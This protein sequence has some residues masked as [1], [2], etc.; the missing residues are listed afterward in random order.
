M[1]NVL[2]KGAIEAV[3][4]RV[5]TTTATATAEELAYLGTALERI[6]GKATVLEVV[7]VADTKLGE[8]TAAMNALSDQQ[9]ARLLARGDEQDARLV[10]QGNTQVDRVTAEGDLQVSVLQSFSPDG[11]QQLTLTPGQ[12]AD[13]TLAAGRHG[14]IGCSDIG[15]AV[16]LPDATTL[17]PGRSRLTL[18]LNKDSFPV[19]VLDATGRVIGQLEPGDLVEFHLLDHG[20]AAGQWDYSGNLAPFWMATSADFQLLYNTYSAYTF[21]SR[22]LYYGRDTSNYPFIQSVSFSGDRIVT[23]PMV[24]LSA[25]AG[26]DIAQVYEIDANRYLVWFGGKKLRVID[27][28]DPTTPV[29]GATVTLVNS[30]HRLDR[31]GT[32]ETWAALRIDTANA[33]IYATPIHLSGAT[34][35][36]GSEAQGTIF[37]TNWHAIYWAFALS[38][39][40][41]GL[42]IQCNNASDNWYRLSA[43]RLL[44]NADGSFTFGTA[45]QYPANA[46]TGSTSNQYQAFHLGGN[47]ALVFYMDSNQRIRTSVCTFD[48]TSSYSADVL[49]NQTTGTW[50][51]TV[52]QL[53]ARRFY[54]SANNKYEIA[55]QVVDVTAVGNAIVQGAVLTLSAGNTLNTN[56]AQL[57]EGRLLLYGSN[58]YFALVALAADGTQTVLQSSFS[59][60]TRNPLFAANGWGGWSVQNLPNYRHVLYLVSQGGSAPYSQTLY[61]VT[62]S[63]DRLKTIPLLHCE[64][65]SV[66]VTSWR[67]DRALMLYGY[68]RRYGIDVG[69]RM[70]FGRDRSLIFYDWVARLGDRQVLARSYL[71]YGSSANDIRLRHFLLKFAEA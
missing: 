12:V 63:N 37:C 59:G 70:R 25:V 2:I 6:G 45:V 16:R 56:V 23:S 62:V 13:I 53:D 69:H 8:M 18:S 17:T 20:T 54:L 31:F 19:G 55:G 58:E 5:Q 24:V 61:R 36:A 64:D 65:G 21:P 48:A 4:D 52:T 26:E 46:N 41:L 71:G 39:S 15:A 68:P 11:V 66:G 3:R 42:L 33:K 60:G 32:R 14:V 30:S 49:M 35:T 28:S 29:I 1:S 57:A 40:A 47:T 7:E 22:Y 43:I 44:C 27:F 9:D 67:A 50:G 38:D 34:L 10:S 51:Y